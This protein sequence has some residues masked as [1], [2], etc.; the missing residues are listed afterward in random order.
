M[1]IT[2]NLS[3][4][5]KAVLKRTILILQVYF[6]KNRC[7]FFL[8]PKS[9]YQDTYYVDFTTSA[10]LTGKDITEFYVIFSKYVNTI[11]Q[12]VKKVLLRNKYQ[13]WLNDTSSQFSTDV[14]MC[15]R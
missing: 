11:I 13:S 8:R 1:L 12:N 7:E 5:K 9:N 3:Y 14:N 4:P 6:L 10:S 2:Q 15:P